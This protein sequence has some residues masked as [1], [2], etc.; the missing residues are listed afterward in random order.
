[1]KKKAMRRNRFK[2][3]VERGNKRIIDILKK[4]QSQFFRQCQTYDVVWLDITSLCCE[5]F[6]KGGNDSQ[7]KGRSLGDT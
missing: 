7:N 3:N 1:M 2:K 4:I 5:N 6:T